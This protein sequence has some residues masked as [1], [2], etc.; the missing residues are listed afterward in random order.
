MKNIGVNTFGLKQ[1]IVR[2]FDETF[3]ALKEMG[4]A[5]I[6]PL[7]VFPQAM[8]ME[9][10]AVAQGF[11]QSGMDGVYW[12]D[13]YAS[14]RIARLRQMGFAVDGAH[15]GLVGIVPG[16][17]A[18]V[19]PYATAFAKE[20]T[21]S[22]LVYSP[23]K[24]TIDEIRPHI[25]TIRDGVENLKAQG[26]DLLFHCHYH[27]FAE[28]QGSCVFDY[29]L[30]EIPEL[31]IQLDVGWVHYAGVDVISLMQKYGRRIVSVHFKDYLLG[32]DSKPLFS[33]I[34]EGCI[35]LSNILAQAAGCPLAENGLIIDQ[36]SSTGDMLQDLR[37]GFLNIQKTMKEQDYGK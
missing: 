20:N 11:R 15:L 34:G 21:L 29:L 36:D 24:K 31:Q 23:Q 1:Q 6:E 22:Y 12:V 28:D 8:G 30:E 26:V 5:S 4:F 13:P 17:L 9:P 18:D 7:V 37:N 32:P 3:S 27:E 16:G 35:P 25:N 33:A 10:E 14:Q 2:D 19:L